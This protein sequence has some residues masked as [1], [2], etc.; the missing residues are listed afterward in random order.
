MSTNESVL[1]YLKS[2][3]LMPEETNFGIAFK[4]QMCSFLIFKDEDDQSFI[5]MAM[6]GIYEV[7]EDTMLDVLMACNEVNKGVK[8]SKA[9]INDDSVWLL[10]ELVLDS[11]PVLDDVIPRGLQILMSS[12]DM[13][14]KNLKG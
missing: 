2:Q 10:Y 4:Y 14:Y 12:R 7:K 13:F 5:Q 6:P 1:N 9:I 3:G 11:T 8:V